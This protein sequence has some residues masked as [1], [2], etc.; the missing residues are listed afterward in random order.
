MYAKAFHLQGNTALHYG[1]SH[2]NTEVIQLLL[3]TQAVNVNLQNR[4]GYTPIMLASLSQIQTE[5]QRDAI[6]KLF[7]V[8]DVN[9][10]ASQVS[11][12]ADIS[13]MSVHAFC[14]WMQ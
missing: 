8:G 9:A 4:A 10:T 5:R 13:L 6:R 11:L 1:V 14:K 7:E 3:D 2:C 12:T